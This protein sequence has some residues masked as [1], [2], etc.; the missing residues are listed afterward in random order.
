MIS[1]RSID[2]L[3]PIVAKLCRDMIEQCKLKNIDIII[4]ST[5]RDNESQ[6]ELY[7]IGRTIKGQDATPKRPMG[8]KVTNA[9]GGQSFHNHRVAFDVVP[10]THGKPI[11]SD[12]NLWKQIGQIG[13][14]V[15]LEWAGEWVSFK[16]F[17]HFQYTGG[18]K[19]ADFQAGKTF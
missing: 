1:S 3:H 9:K 8:R 13:K 7:K 2:E 15:G 10:T 11:W 14:S 5:Y 17:P 4:T 18:L 6:N 12:D 16:E 19:L